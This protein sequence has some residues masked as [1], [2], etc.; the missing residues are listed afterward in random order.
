MAS[1]WHPSVTS[2]NAVSLYSASTAGY[3]AHRQC[4]RTNPLQRS[5][6]HCF[7]DGDTLWIKGL[8]SAFRGALLCSYG[9]EDDDVGR[10]IAADAAGNSYLV[11]QFVSESIT[12]PTVPLAT[13]LF[14]VGAS[15]I[16]VIKR[17]AQGVPVW[18]RV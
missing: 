14:R 11:G 1:P 17:D 4:G 7:T 13:T 3:I 6:V 16:F 8:V 12:V 5:K 10:G 9:G 2:W 18:A 15:S